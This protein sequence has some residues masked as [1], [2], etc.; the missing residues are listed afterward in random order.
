MVSLS[1][2]HNKHLSPDLFFG[3]LSQPCL[4]S[5]HSCLPT[6]ILISF[7]SCLFQDEIYKTV[8]RNRISSNSSFN[9]RALRDTLKIWVPGRFPTI[10][11][12]GLPFSFLPPKQ[13][14][15]T[16][17]DI[18]QDWLINIYLSLN[19]PKCL[20]FQLRVY[21]KEWRIHWIWGKKGKRKF[22]D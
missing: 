4:W 19:S 20:F 6:H 21:L 5:F 10:E 9:W 16:Q 14:W 2:P 7:Y 8:R 15:E 3:A 1:L 22:V 17:S 18:F 12:R 13:R 11:Q